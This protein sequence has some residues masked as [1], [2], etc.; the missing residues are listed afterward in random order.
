MTVWYAALGATGGTQTCT[1]DGHL[2]RVT[3]ARC[4]DIIKSPDDEHECSEHVE[5]WN[6]H[7]RKKKESLS[8]LRACCYIHF[9][10]PTHAL[11]N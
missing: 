4:I 1:L 10:L 7:I 5:I 2:R 3:Y 11:I 9:S 8:F 6:K